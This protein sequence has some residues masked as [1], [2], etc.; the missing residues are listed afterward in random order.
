[1]ARDSGRHTV[2]LLAEAS[3][4][5]V[6]V[7]APLDAL[8][9]P[10]NDD[11]HGAAL[12]L[13]PQGAAWGTP[14]GTAM[15]ESSLLSRFTRVLVAPFEGLYRRAWLWAMESVVS[16]ISD[17]LDQWEND[18]GLPDACVDDEQTTS[19]RLKAVAAKIRS[20]KLVTPGD[21]A[22]LAAS[23]G[24]EVAIEEPAIFECGF[25]EC[26]GEHET[27]AAREEIYVIVRVK[28]LQVNYFTCGE[29]ECGYDPLFDYGDTAKLLCIMRAAAPAWTI[30][31]L[32]DWRYFGEIDE[33]PGA[34]VFGGS[35]V[36]VY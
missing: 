15:A 36:M 5:V 20:E 26:G 19:E 32:G 13:W 8:A 28:D 2:T 22:R 11:L 14:D 16:G 21:F 9:D 31:V 6:A 18:L 24:Y 25:S 33:I 17:T 27:G 10:D 30:P 23:Y 34:V 29:S 35:G 7:S 4:D 12:T 3:E 1:M